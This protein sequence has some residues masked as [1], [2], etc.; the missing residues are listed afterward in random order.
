MA[1]ARIGAVVKFI[2]ILG[3]RRGVGI[4]TGYMT[5]LIDMMKTTK[6]ATE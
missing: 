3:I 6:V 4:E 1:I 5:K 2:G